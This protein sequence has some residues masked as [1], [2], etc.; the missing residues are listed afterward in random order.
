DRDNILDA[1]EIQATKYLCESG[2]ALAPGLKVVD[3]N[4]DLLGDALTS[5]PFGVVLRTS[6]GHIVTLAWDGA[7]VPVKYVLFSG[8]ACTGSP[9]IYNET[10]AASI[11]EKSAY[12]SQQHGACLVPTDTALGGGVASVTGSYLTYTE[13]GLG[14]QMTAGTGFEWPVDPVSLTDV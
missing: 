10:G 2:G 3:G 13:V 4:G 11:H 9:K 14:C 6:T 1:G 7:P 12:W 5:D 8:P